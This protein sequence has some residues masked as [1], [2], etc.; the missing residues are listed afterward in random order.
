MVSGD[1]S[2]SPPSKAQTFAALER[3]R[4]FLWG[5]CYR[6]TGSASD[7]EDLVQETFV[8]A[9]E[10]PPA[11]TSAAWRPWL[12][13]VAM[14]LSRDHLR[15]RK[16]RQYVGTWLPTPVDTPDADVPEPDPAEEA[17][18][19]PEARYGLLE[20]ASFAFLYALE[21]LTP[22]QR[23][24]LVLRDAFD[25]S[26]NEAGVAL[27]MTDENVR[28]TL[29]RARKAMDTYDRDRFVPGKDHGATVRRVLGQV[30]ACFAARDIEGVTRLMAADARMVGDGGGVFHTARYEMRG[31]EKIARMYGK[32][33]TRSGP[34]LRVEVKSVN[35]LPAFIADDPSPLKPNAPRAVIMIDLDGTGRVRTLFTV[36]AP[37]K[38]THVRFPSSERDALH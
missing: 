37:A 25:F 35:G 14:N 32:L 7:A 10:R 4:Q 15:R 6:M 21:I 23:A 2:P 17:E 30:M 24:V 19:S 28:I 11:D 36:L 29:H 1:V 20:S 9:I 16:R 13:R 18:R 27:G 5:L 33:S 8:R 12:V 31:A 38:L 34:D 22:S 3:E 26:S